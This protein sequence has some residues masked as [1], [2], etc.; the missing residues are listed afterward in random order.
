MVI[1][2]KHR[3]LAPGAG[4]VHHVVMDH[5]TKPRDIKFVFPA[6][7]EQISANLECYVKDLEAGS[8]VWP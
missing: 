6:V 7:L 1:G 8:D 4:E 2:K 3:P 5:T